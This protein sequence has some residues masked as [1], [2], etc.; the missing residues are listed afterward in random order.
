M[1]GTRSEKA[2]LADFWMVTGDWPASAIFAG[3]PY[4]ARAKKALQGGSGVR[5]RHRACPS[6]LS[7]A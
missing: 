1:V 2:G 5:F 3:Q 7:L 4:R 6:D